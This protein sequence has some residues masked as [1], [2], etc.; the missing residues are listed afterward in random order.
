MTILKLIKLWAKY[1]K[2]CANLEGGV[3]ES[4]IEDFLDWLCYK[5]KM[6]TYWGFWNSTRYM[7][8]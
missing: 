8:K 1:K 6:K 7:K 5:N 4:T 2:N 3:R